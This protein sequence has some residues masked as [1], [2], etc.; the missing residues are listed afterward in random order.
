MGKHSQMDVFSK[1]LRE[2]DFSKEQIGNIQSNQKR[3]MPR[4]L[5][6]FSHTLFHSNGTFSL[7]IIIHKLCAAPPP[8][9]LNCEEVDG[10][11]GNWE[12]NFVLRT[13]RA[14]KGEGNCCQFV[15]IPSDPLLLHNFCP[16][17]KGNTL[18]VKYKK[19]LPTSSVIVFIRFTMAFCSFSSNRW[20][21]RS[22]SWDLAVSLAMS[23]N[24]VINAASMF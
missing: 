2:L 12:D 8:A 21:V 9:I 3:G 17:P 20:N 13:V 11:G 6:Q 18:F 16:N 15:Q 4:N 5:C 1:V 14:P 23:L 7:V 24:F 22:S 19:K 10:K